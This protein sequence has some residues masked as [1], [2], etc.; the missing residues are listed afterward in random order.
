MTS[1]PL[2]RTLP[3]LRQNISTNMTHHH[4]QHLQKETTSFHT[5]E[6]IPTLK[7]QSLTSPILKRNTVLRWMSLTHHHLSSKATLFLISVKMKT[8]SS[9]NR[10]LPMLKQLTVRGIQQETEMVLGFS[11]ELTPT[12]STTL[13]VKI[14]G[15]PLRCHLLSKLMPTLSLL[16]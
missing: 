12:N 4:H 13:R 1:R 3:L 5:L 2:R 9:Q 11:Q 8:L 7:A 16:A 14:T 15:H 10:T 6:K